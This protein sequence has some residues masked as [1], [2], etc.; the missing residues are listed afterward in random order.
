MPENR[1]RLNIHFTKFTRRKNSG[2]YRTA[3]NQDILH[4]MLPE[5]WSP[6]LNTNSQIIRAG[7]LKKGNRIY[8]SSDEE[9]D[10]ESQ[11]LK[12]LSSDF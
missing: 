3:T 7:W 12:A 11:P 9:E 6:G 5:S 10:R 8:Y 2:G 4:S 1:G